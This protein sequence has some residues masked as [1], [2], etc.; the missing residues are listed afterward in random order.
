MLLTLISDP[1][2]PI[3]E[4]APDHPALSLTDR[5]SPVIEACLSNRAQSAIIYAAQLPKEFFDLSSGHAGS[6]L[7]QLRLYGGF[8]LAIICA[9]GSVAFSSRF[10]ELLAQGSS[11]RNLGVF[12]TRVAALEWL[13]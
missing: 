13:R 12:E 9:P 7:Q 8:R 2:P 10:G 1:G 3:L 11:G 6:M 4:A 5:A